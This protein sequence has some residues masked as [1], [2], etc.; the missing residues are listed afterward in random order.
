MAYGTLALQVLAQ[1]AEGQTARLS[2]EHAPLGKAGA[3]LALGLSRRQ[4][5]DALG[6]DL[7]NEKLL[8]KVQ[9][10]QTQISLKLHLEFG[11]A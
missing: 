2:L 11:I 6:L 1:A 7:P 10:E 8:P 9:P 3:R 5:D 4:A